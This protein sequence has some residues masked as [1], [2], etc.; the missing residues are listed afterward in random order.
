MSAVCPHQTAASH[1]VTG[2][3][4]EARRGRGSS[5]QAIESFSLSL[6]TPLLAHGLT[7]L[8]SRV[9]V[10]CIWAWCQKEALAI[11]LHQHAFLQEPELPLVH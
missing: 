4:R 8:W 10:M 6:S 1:T 7:E 9:A 3:E 5:P 11:P 2:K